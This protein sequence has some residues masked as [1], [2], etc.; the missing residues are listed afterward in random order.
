LESQIYDTNRQ[1]R[2]D[3]AAR[4][5]GLGVD[6]NAAL[7]RG[8]IDLANILAT[9]ERRT[10]TAAATGAQTAGQAAAEATS[11]SGQQGVRMVGDIMGSPFL[12]ALRSQNAGYLKSGNSIGVSRG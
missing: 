6:A 5:S 2:D 4:L 11:A 8:D 12:E 10:G 9:G 1:R 7:A 3:A